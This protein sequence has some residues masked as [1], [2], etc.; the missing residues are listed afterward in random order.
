MKYS[1]RMFNKLPRFIPSLTSTWIP[2]HI[3]NELTSPPTNY[4]GVLQALFTLPF[5][6]A[7]QDLV[8]SILEDCWKKFERRGLVELLIPVGRVLVLLYAAA[9]QE[10]EATELLS[11][12]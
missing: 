1:S 10:D 8:W 4:G 11:K 2:S 9:R 3:Y 7:S 5:Q 6:G 12:I